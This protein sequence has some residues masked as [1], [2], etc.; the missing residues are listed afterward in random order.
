MFCHTCHAA[1]NSGVKKTMIKDIDTDVAVNGNNLRIRNIYGIGHENEQISN[2]ILRVLDEILTTALN[3][4]KRANHFCAFQN[5]IDQFQKM[6]SIYKDCFQKDLFSNKFSVK[7]K[8]CLNWVNKKSKYWEIALK[9]WVK[10]AE[11]ELFILQN[12]EQILSESG[13]KLIEDEK[14]LQKNN[15]VVV[16]LYINTLTN[17]KIYNI[18]NNHNTHLSSE[19]KSDVNKSDGGKPYKYRDNI[20][21]TT[22][23]LNQNKSS[24]DESNDDESNEDLYFECLNV[25]NWHENENLRAEAIKKF[26]QIKELAE[27]NNSKFANKSETFL[28]FFWVKKEEGDKLPNTFLEV[29]MKGS[30]VFTSFEPP[31]AVD[32]LVFEPGSNTMLKWNKP[33]I[34]FENVTSYLLLFKKIDFYKE[35]EM[36]TIEVS[37]STD[38]FTYFKVDDANLDKSFTYEVSVLCTSMEKKLMS[39]PKSIQLLK[40][41]TLHSINFEIYRYRNVLIS[42][43]NP[44]K[45]YGTENKFEIS[46]KS[47]Y[48]KDKWIKSNI[49][50]NNS[51]K[52]LSDLRFS[53]IYLFKIV[54]EDS[55]KIEELCLY[56]NKIPPLKIQ[57]A[58]FKDNEMIVEFCCLINEK[59]NYT[60]EWKP[61]ADVQTWNRYLPLNIYTKYDNSN[62][63]RIIIEINNAKYGFYLVRAKCSKGTAENEESE[64]SEIMPCFKSEFNSFDENGSIYYNNDDKINEENL[65]SVIDRPLIEIFQGDYKLPAINK[66]IAIKKWV[67]SIEISD[68]Q[69]FNNPIT[70]TDDK[71]FHKGVYHPTDLLFYYVK[72]MDFSRR[73]KLYRN[74]AINSLAVPV[75]LPLKNPCYM[76]MCLHSVNLLWKP[77][78]R[79]LIERNA[80]DAELPAISMLR[81]GTLENISKAEVGNRL[82]GT[83][84]HGFFTRNALLS[85]NLRSSSNGLVEGLWLQNT[86]NINTS[87]EG[88]FVSSFCLL[89]LR[90][91]AIDHKLTS[92]KLFSSSDVVILLCDRAIF[93]DSSKKLEKFLIDTN[94]ILKK[95]N[96]ITLIIYYTR[97]AAEF[98][99]EF[100]NFIKNKLQKIKKVE[101]KTEFSDLEKL[102]K[103]LVDNIPS[104]KSLSHRFKELNKESSCINKQYLNFDFNK[105]L[106]E[107]MSKISEEHTFLPFQ[108]RV[109]KFSQMQRELNQCEDFDQY[110]DIE[111]KMNNIRLNNIN[112][113]Y[114]IPK[115][116]L[117]FMKNIYLS[118]DKTVFI[119]S[120]KDTLNDWSKENI[121]HVKESIEKLKNE[122]SDENSIVDKLKGLIKK[123]KK[124][125]VGLEH[126]LRELGEIYE[127]SQLI[128]ESILKKKFKELPSMA[129]S[130]LLKGFALEIL[131]G[132]GFSVNIKWIRDVLHA[133]KKPLK[134]YLGIDREPRIF[135]LSV[136]GAQSSG[137]STLL[138]TM[139]GLE[140][141]VCS[142]RTTIGS[143]MHLVP[144]TIPNFNFDAFF[145]ID[146][147]GLLAPEFVGVHSH[148]NEI[149]TLIFGISD[150]TIINNRSEFITKENFLEISA[151][152]LM[153]MKM[154]DFHPRCIFVQQ[155]CDNT[156]KD[157]NSEN[158]EK[159]LETLNCSIKSYAN[160]IGKKSITR[161][162]DIVDIRCD[163]FFYF[164]HLNSGS[165]SISSLY[166]NACSELREHIL[167]NVLSKSKTFRTMDKIS[168][169]INQVWKSILKENFVMNFLNAAYVEA[170][171]EVD[172]EIRK[173]KSK[174]EE[175]LNTLTQ[176]LCLDIDQESIETKKMELNKNATLYFNMLSD[177][178]NTFIANKKKKSGI[179]KDLY[180]QCVDS[181]KIFNERCINRY[182]LQ[183]QRWFEHFKQK[184]NLKGKFKIEIHKQAREVAKQCLLTDGIKV[185]SNEECNTEFEKFWNSTS[186][187][188]YYEFEK[189]SVYDKADFVKDLQNELFLTTEKLNNKIEH[190]EDYSIKFGDHLEIPF[191]PEWIQESLHL[192]E[193]VESAEIEMK[194]CLDFQEVEGG[195]K[196]LKIQPGLFFD[197][198]TLV[199]IYLK[200]VEE[201]I[202]Q[203]IA[204]HNNKEL[205]VLEKPVQTNGEIKAFL[206]YHA[207]HLAVKP[208][209]QAQ[210]NFQ[211]YLDIPNQ[212]QSMKESVKEEFLMILNKETNI[213]IAAKQYASLLH[214]A[215]V[216]K[217]L[218]EA[219][220]SAESAFF[221]KIPLKEHLHG[222]VLLDILHIISKSSFVKNKK[223]EILLE[224]SDKIYI[225]QYFQNPFRTIDNK[226]YAI[227]D[228]YYS[229][230]SDSLEVCFK[231]HVSQVESIINDLNT[232]VQNEDK[233]SLLFKNEYVRSLHIDEMDIIVT[234]TIAKDNTTED[235]NEILNKI[236]SFLLLAKLE[237]PNLFKTNFRYKVFYAVSKELITCTATC[238]FCG[239]PCDCSHGIDPS[240]SCRSHRPEGFGGII[241]NGVFFFFKNQFVTNICTDS[242][243]CKS[244]FKNSDT[245]YKYIKYSEYKKVDNNTF[246]VGDKYT[247]WDISDDTYNEALIFWKYVTYNL[248]S[249]IDVIFP[250]ARK[251]NVD[252]W[253]SFSRKEAQEALEKEFHIVNLAT[254]VENRY[255]VNLHDK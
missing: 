31:S 61:E 57:K 77:N 70:W 124:M 145:V 40:K 147:E 2:D 93:K 190:S 201:I 18:L 162:S 139:F 238:P 176:I 175:H 155:G 173:W 199:N 197:S 244:F 130:L 231:A 100:S 146:T 208:F 179:F 165:K 249:V 112:N 153:K 254:L 129:A 94:N 12:Y 193:L 157:Y 172:I 3:L 128:E 44:V 133:L 38:S 144:I 46:Y 247:S 66:E 74:L 246:S 86:Q 230:F 188:V 101:Y 126:L 48:E 245:K 250:D 205:V 16:T 23:E 206:I 111:N 117:E 177:E 127:T 64:W 228:Y 233:I 156:A 89:N 181:M 210:E 32:D 189:F 106:L 136:L 218:N 150:L 34:G 211:Q 216:E 186:M 183:I 95:N 113:L 167:V 204:I 83:K 73:R 209:K 80:A 71:G 217:V 213:V 164:P 134:K 142:G 81:I 59:L 169:Q 107:D 239:A 42:W 27:A 243:K 241:W 50:F 54:T 242:I 26:N 29:W 221:N 79:S 22:D 131:N 120:V 47:Q 236:L 138:N 41:L 200:K 140:N 62:E 225:I 143:F 122:I 13:V 88:N 191:K 185:F 97:A 35:F 20:E 33:E 24:D 116:I 25:N 174:L 240:H 123:K 49:D 121:P 224:D 159:I 14:E 43:A 180:A 195:Y 72:N 135:V 119:Y 118:E 65:N 78:M 202:D 55:S 115:T 68:H 160:T 67:K 21:S 171:Y 110:K 166:V 152:A 149:S 9:D 215:I 212:I 17:D 187:A 45:I 30:R 248:M 82:I 19:K 132:D 253:S 235:K 63:Q 99:K 96:M 125:T 4:K 90:G 84:E 87:S 234:S 98:M 229:K 7:C 163:N 5:K 194:K 103:C 36:K 148:D 192:K 252:R 92:S 161:F 85:N 56:T 227:I 1:I 178:F 251:V 182:T 237:V 102:L 75:I 69:C 168:D 114:H 6:V 255:L 220:R 154:I 196:I 207:A 11:K 198:T 91:D 219:L 158:R 52:W 214:K 51:K 104:P 223:R 105:R 28:F 109:K 37:F 184:D 39:K 10:N 76:D 226:I 141:P 53:S 222:L 60:F 108:S 15:A 137:K 8:R 151:C 170:H 203:Q 58:F 232:S